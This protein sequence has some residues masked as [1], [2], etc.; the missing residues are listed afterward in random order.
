[1]TI[2]S[3]VTLDTR[4]RRK[5]VAIRKVNG[6]KSRDIYK[7]F[8]RVYITIIT[9]ALVIAVPLSVLLYKLIV[10]TIVK[11]TDDQTSMTASPVLPIIIGVF[12]VIAFVLLIV[13]WQIRKVMKTDPASVIAKE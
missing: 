1:M 6:A 2:F 5:E 10:M 4:G 11:I 3:A 9:V 13:W 8:G 7:L 12:T